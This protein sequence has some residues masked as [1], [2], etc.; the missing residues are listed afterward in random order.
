MDNGTACH[1]PCSLPQNGEWNDVGVVRQKQKE[2]IHR[3]S[4]VVTPASKRGVNTHARVAM[5][6]GGR[7]LAT[8]GTENK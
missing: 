4:G 8:G 6:R 7:A 1:C 3:R 5:A 2:E